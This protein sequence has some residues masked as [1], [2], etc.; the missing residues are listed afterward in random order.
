MQ[1]LP[2]MQPEPKMMIWERSFSEL[3]ERM[4]NRTT[5]LRTQMVHRQNLLFTTDD[6]HQHALA[7]KTDIARAV[8][9]LVATVNL[10]R[11]SRLSESTCQFTT[12]QAQIAGSQLAGHSFDDAERRAS[13]NSRGS[14]PNLQLLHQ[15]AER[16]PRADEVNRSPHRA[17]T[18]PVVQ[19]S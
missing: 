9:T 7:R 16:C 8:F 3:G 10:I 1:R 18:A 12:C 13:S 15:V 5:D 6:S 19:R 17:L 4:H 11:G 14:Q 2:L